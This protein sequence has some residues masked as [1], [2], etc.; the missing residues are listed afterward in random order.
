LTPEK[1]DSDLRFHEK[2]IKLEHLSPSNKM[3]DNAF[4]EEFINLQ[5]CTD[6]HLGCSFYSSSYDL[7]VVL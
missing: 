6:V 4:D 1:E 5:E 3:K 2:E 7:E